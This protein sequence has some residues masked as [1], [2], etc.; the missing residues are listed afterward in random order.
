[1]NRYLYETISHVALAAAVLETVSDPAREAIFEYASLEDK[2]Y[3][4]ELHE[5]RRFNIVSGS[6]PTLTAAGNAYYLYGKLITQH[7]IVLN[8]GQP[9]GVARSPN[10][11]LQFLTINQPSRPSVLPVKYE[12]T[13]HLKH[14]ITDALEYIVT[15]DPNDLNFV[16]NIAREPETVDSVESSLRN[17]LI[18]L[19]LIE[20]TPDANLIATQKGAAVERWAMF[21]HKPIYLVFTGGAIEKFDGLEALLI[22][23]EASVG[24]EYATPVLDQA[25]RFGI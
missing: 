20:C 6:P 19:D 13:S 12:S 25:T 24:D 7:L 5:L 21:L 3:E 22:R 15:L 14:Q 16:I 11:L 23:L 4:H 18:K 17:R 9:L 8:D 1:M 2:K 10:A